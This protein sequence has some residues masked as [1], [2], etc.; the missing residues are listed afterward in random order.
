MN[1]EEEQ[2]CR[3]ALTII[4]LCDALQIIDEHPDRPETGMFKAFQMLQ[5][6]FAAWSAAQAQQQAPQGWRHRLDEMR[7]AAHSYEDRPELFYVILDSVH[8]MLT[9]LENESV[10]AQQEQPAQ[11]ERNG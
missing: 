1:N 9:E 10:D 2:Q 5:G 3:E 7:G 6:R 8:E 11:G 4:D